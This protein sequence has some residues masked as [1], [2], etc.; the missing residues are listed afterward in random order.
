MN[1]IKS[2]LMGCLFAAASGYGA[3]ALSAPQ[4]GWWW[5][6]A[7]SGRGFFVESQNGVTF[8]GAYLYNADG[9]AVW[10]V[11]GGKNG[12][13]Y[14]YTGPLYNM[15][16]GQTLFGPYATP[17]GPNTVGTI[18]VHFSDNTH[19]TVTWPGGTV[20]IERHVFGTG[21]AAFKPYTGWW[22]NPAESG[23]GYSIEVQGNNLFVVG[24]SYD[25]SGRPVWYFSA[26]PMSTASTYHGDVLQFGNG[27][28][29]D[30]PYH[31]PGPPTAIA[32]VDVDFNAVNQAKLTFTR[33]AAL[34]EGGPKQGEQTLRVI[35][36]QFLSSLAP[37][38]PFWTGTV[39]FSGHV[40]AAQAGIS[41]ED[42]HFTVRVANLIFVQ[43]PSYREAYSMDLS[44]AVVTY[45]FSQTVNTLV[46]NCSG[47][48]DGR[49]EFARLAEQVDASLS[50]TESGLYGLTM[51]VNVP[52]TYPFDCP[53]PPPVHA[54]LPFT[55]EFELN[56]RE[57]GVVVGIVGSEITNYSI[58]GGSGSARVDWEFAPRTEHP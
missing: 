9:R 43:D 51:H 23:S 14:N 7:E 3:L 47:Q 50:V 33:A 56:D 58:P 46:G 8:I 16:S 2:L 41:S 27:Q 10:Y 52:I 15:S 24:F 35:Q 40:Q 42:S 19:G 39:A 34:T 22:W 30:G 6:P 18:T 21:D 20:A 28:T 26:G 36:P 37:L 45:T 53:G 1:T 49:S 55:I 11:A 54:E 17:V 5:N 13:P 32:K 31:P 57:G 4:T 29:I 25:G 44:G 48:V 38:P 12:D